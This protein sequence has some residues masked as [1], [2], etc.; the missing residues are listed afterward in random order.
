MSNLTANDR[1]KLEQLFGMGS[2]YVMG[3][4][5]RTFRGFFGE[6][7]VDIYDDRYNIRGDSKA[8]RLRAF[9]DLNSNYMVARITGELI[10]YGQE[11]DC[12]T[13]APEK[14]I[15]ECLEIVRLLRS[16]IESD[17]D[18]LASLSEGP[19]FEILV[20]HVREAIEKG[21][22]EGGLDRLHMFATKYVRSLCHR[23]GIAVDRQKPLQ[24]L[25][26]E[27]V[28]FLVRENRLESKMAR[29]ILKS[30][31]S[32]LDTFNEVRND[33]SLAHDNP[34]LNHEESLLIFTHVVAT[35]R[36]VKYIEER[37]T[38]D[39]EETPSFWDDLPF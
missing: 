13:Y 19:D 29:T 27:Y 8:N 3:F 26:G 37:L 14:L 35:I 4:S 23:H 21:Q 28:K 7:N 11:E 34:V 18:V 15:N 39:A 31:I 38:N 17:L 33:R 30:S 32:V 6:Y 36:F 12:F 16:D 5:N 9:W 24:S 20:Q 10:S 1:R 2:G 22:P 25:F